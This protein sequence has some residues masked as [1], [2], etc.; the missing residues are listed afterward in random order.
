M[1]TNAVRIAAL[2]A[3]F[4]EYLRR[5]RRGESLI[6][7]DRDRPVAQLVPIDNHRDDAL[8]VTPGAGTYARMGDMPLPDCVQLSE[9]PVRYLLEDRESE[10]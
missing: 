2:K 7:M 8:I 1:T 5:V 6:V 9:D 10:P 3:K 4:S